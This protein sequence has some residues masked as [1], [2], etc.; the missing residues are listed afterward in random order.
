M[1]VSAVAVPSQ[2]NQET[3]NDQENIPPLKG[4]FTGQDTRTGYQCTYAQPLV[5]FQL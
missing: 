5:D 1:P 4:I 3:R 2:L